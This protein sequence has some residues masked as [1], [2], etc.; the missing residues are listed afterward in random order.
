MLSR[1]L[2][3]IFIVLVV[4]SATSARRYFPNGAVWFEDVTNAALDSESQQ[5]ISW[6]SESGGWGKFSNHRIR[7]SKLHS[8]LNKQINYIL[9]HNYTYTILFEYVLTK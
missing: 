3:S 4:L 2:C 6:L 9:R 7:P 5:I 8:H 1:N